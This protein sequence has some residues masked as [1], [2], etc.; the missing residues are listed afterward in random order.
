MKTQNCIIPFGKYKGKDL[1][2]VAEH[3]PHYLNWLS[4]VVYESELKT[5]LD[6]FLKTKYFA[7]CW[8]EDQER[9]YK[10]QELEPERMFEPLTP[11]RK[12]GHDDDGDFGDEHV[13][14][15]GGDTDSDDGEVGW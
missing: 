12:W 6:K 2:F 1:L 5:E 4:T 10:S 14:A 7:D 3:N 8:L 11:S 15:W 13:S 9:R